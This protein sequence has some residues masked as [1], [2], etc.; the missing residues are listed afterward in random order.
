MHN[1][2]DSFNYHIN[3]KSTGHHPGQQKVGKG[4]GN[5]VWDTQIYLIIPIPEELISDRQSEIH[6]SKYM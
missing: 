2:L 6:L 3:W 5:G 1:P 4:D